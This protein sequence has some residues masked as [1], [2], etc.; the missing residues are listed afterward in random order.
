MNLVS[1]VHYHVFHYRNEFTYMYLNEFLCSVTEGVQIIS[2]LFYRI[3]S[4]FRMDFIFV[5][6]LRVE[7]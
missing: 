1:I 6:Q 4:Y 2:V 5:Q 7:N 3:A